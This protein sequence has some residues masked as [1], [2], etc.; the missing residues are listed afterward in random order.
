MKFKSLVLAGGV[1]ALA[2]GPIPGA[3]TSL[4]LALANNGKGGGSEN[5]GGGNGNS[6]GNGGGNGNSSVQA[7]IAP[8][9]KTQSSDG[10]SAPGSHGLLA[11]ELKGLNAV[12]ANPNALLHASPNSQVGRIALYQTAAVASFEAADAVDEAQA[13]LDLLPVPTRS[14]AEIRAD[15]AALDP[16]ALDYETALAD[17]KAERDA[18]RAYI[19]A[20]NALSD[21]T[22]AAE[23]AAAE[24]EAALLTASGGRVL[25]DDAVAYIRAALGL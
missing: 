22:D 10:G 4:D 2:L 7:S 13:A 23:L 11:S 20:K 25:S 19:D 24:E 12:K 3:L 1:V 18:A 17:L 21:A 8:S 9:A 16:A 15:I 5:A 14:L 6:G